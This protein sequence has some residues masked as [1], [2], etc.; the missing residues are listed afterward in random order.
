M[1]KR[2][3]KFTIPDISQLEID[4][5]AE[6][7]RSGWITTGPKTKLLEKKLAEYLTNKE[8]QECAR[9]VCLN[10]A[11]ASLEIALRLLGVGPQSGG[12][13]KDE[14]I[15]CAYTYTSS[16]SV[17]NHVGAKIVLIDCSNKNGSIEMNYEK[18]EG[19]INENTKAIIPVDI[20]GVPC[21]Y[22]KIFEIVNR[23]KDIFVA[24]SKVQKSLGRV[25]IIDDAAHAIGALYKGKRIGTI[26][27]FTAF[28][29]HAT[30]NFTTGEGGALTFKHFDGIDDDDLYH[31]IQLY[32]LHGQNKDAYSKER[33]GA[34]EYD[35]VGTWYKS[36][37]TDI[38][39]AIGLGQL[40]RY[41]EMVSRRHEII[42]M[43]DKAFK[44]LGIET[45]NHCTNDY[46]SSGHIYATR[47]P[48]I[49]CAERNEI[50]VELSK[51]G[52][53]ANVHFKPLPLLTAYKNLGFDIKEYP[54]AYAKFENEISLPL[55]SKLSNE[56]VNYVIECFKSVVSKYLDKENKK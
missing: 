10:S 32:S 50:I 12:S 2:E 8:K 51:F 36:N 43:Y 20:A 3:I 16:A 37:M 24:T 28:S 44:P 40:E 38:M 48:G 13:L 19:A 22:E 55:Y 56:D 1:E 34:W 14:V 31:Q 49:N 45:L 41:P 15:T 54:I 35:V 9:C 27:D 25:A 53:C 39:A 18:L 11:T 30:K 21:D 26:A 42:K 29:F 5:V 4:N 47:I 23:K 6:V 46:I 7:L 17:I 33:L 52:V